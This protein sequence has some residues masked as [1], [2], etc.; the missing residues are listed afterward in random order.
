MWELCIIIFVFLSLPFP[1]TIFIHSDS[2]PCLVSFPLFDHISI[3]IK[4]TASSSS[5]TANDS[6]CHNWCCALCLIIKN[7]FRKLHNCFPF[8]LLCTFLSADRITYADPT[9]CLIWSSSCMLTPPKGRPHCF[10]TIAFF[11]H[12]G[13]PCGAFFSRHMRKMTNFLMQ[14]SVDVL[15]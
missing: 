12:V 5:Q 4:A 3:H 11:H 10:Q 15:K 8:H 1:F 13:V 9:L 6:G 14:I 7:D 2:C